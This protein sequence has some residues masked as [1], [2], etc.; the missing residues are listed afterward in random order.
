MRVEMNG[1]EVITKGS[2]ENN[3]IS[4]Q[5]PYLSRKQHA[6]IWLMNVQCVFLSIGTCKKILYIKKKK[7]HT[8]THLTDN[9]L[10]QHCII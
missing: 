7:K 2:N 4:I 10:K 5:N 3:E 9:I 8:H 6:N 1:E